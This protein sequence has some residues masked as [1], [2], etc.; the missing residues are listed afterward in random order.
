MKLGNVAKNFHVNEYA[1]GFGDKKAIY[2]RLF[3]ENLPKK[4]YR[5]KFG[6]PDPTSLEAKRY[7]SYKI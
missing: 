3:L 1:G 2:L 5:A 6:H 7:L 4:Q